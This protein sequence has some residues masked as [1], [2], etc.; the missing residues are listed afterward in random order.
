MCFH[1]NVEELNEKVNSAMPISFIKWRDRFC[2]VVKRNLKNLK[3]LDLIEMIL[4]ER[5]AKNFNGCTFF[6]LEIGEFLRRNMD[7]DTIQQTKEAVFLSLPLM[8]ANGLTQNLHHCITNDW[9]E[10]TFGK[11]IGWSQVN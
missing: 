11:K 4:D 5:K 1:Q 7:Q 6:P 8:A 10:L 2:A 3:Q 9:K